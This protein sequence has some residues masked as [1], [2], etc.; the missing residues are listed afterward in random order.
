[1]DDDGREWPYRGNEDAMGTMGDDGEV[2]REEVE[3]GER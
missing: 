3:R 2:K 1:M